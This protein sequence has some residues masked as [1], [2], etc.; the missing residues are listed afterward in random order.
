MPSPPPP[1]RSGLILGLLVSVFVVMGALVA[2]PRARAQSSYQLFESGPVRPMALSP[3]GN[4]LFVTNTPDGQLE[5][6]DVATNGSLIHRTSVGVGL[7]PVAV[8]AR[9]DDEVWVVNHLSDSVSIVALSGP[10]PRVVRTLLVGDEPNDIVFAGPGGDRAFVSAAHRGQSAPVPDGDYDVPG[11]GRADVYVFDAANLGESLEGDRLAVVT[12]FG[13]RPRALA[14]NAAGDRVYVAVFRSGNRTAVLNEGAVCDTSGANRTNEVVQGPCV[15]GFGANQTTSPGGLPTPLKNHAGA[16]GPETGLIVQQDRDGGATGAWLDELGRDWS[17]LIRFDLPDEDVFTLDAS[18]PVPVEIG[19]PFAGVGTTLFNMAVHPITGRIFVTNT[20]ARN[21]V[22]FEGPGSHVSTNGL[23]PGGEPASVRGDLARSRITIL[24]PGSG[25]VLPRHLNKHIPYGVV[26]VPAGVEERSLAT[27]LG[28]AFSADGSTVYVAGF[29]SSRIGV[30][31]VAGLESDTFAVQAND[32]IP[33]GGGGPSSVLRLGDRLVVTTRF[34]NALRVVDPITKAEFQRIP[35]TNPE[36][37]SVIAG[38][39]F[40][41]DANLTGSNGEASCASC[42]LFGDMDDLAWDLGDPDADVV[43]NGNPINPVSQFLCLISGTL[44]TQFHPHKGPMATQSLRGLENMGPQHWRGDRQGDE[45]AAFEA[46]N[47]A[48]PGLVGRDEGELTPQQMT[49]FREFAL[50]LRYPPNPIRRLDNGLRATPGGPS[51]A[52]GAV[53]YGT[54]GNPGPT[55]DNL[56]DCQGCHTLDAATGHFG[57]NGQSTFDAEPQVFKVPHLRN[58]YQ[59][60]GAFGFPDVGNSDGPFTHQGRQVRSTGFSHDGSI[61]TLDR[62]L[63]ANVFTLSA[64]EQEDLEAFMMVFP[65]DFAPMVGQQVTL[66]ASLLAG[67]QAAALNA[68]ADLLLARSGT[69]FDSAV[70]GG[71]VNECD[72]IARVVDVGSGSPRGFLRLPDGTF[73]PDDG[74]TPIGEAALRAMASVVGQELTFSCVPPGSGSRMALDRDEDQIPNGL[75]NCA[76]A[77]NG[78]GGGT[79]VAG[80]AAALAT[81]CVTDVDCGVGGVCSTAQEDADLDGVGDAC[82]PALVPEPEMVWLLAAGSLLLAAMASR[83]GP[84]PLR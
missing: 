32:P 59:K 17:P 1:A 69:P 63:G 33:V 58:A 72:A 48:F 2:V 15:V 47:V 81:D 13:D 23:K 20:E 60:V 51:E 10:A 21:Q 34:D 70:L 74:G 77:P 84:R 62:F 64:A 19:A 27:P 12:L 50:Q 71:S 43:A 82:E 30:Y 4:R 78:P 39:P 5:V 36:P 52:N 6:F 61:D 9:S 57:G 55:S 53:L 25:A 28:M 66:S 67:P 11:Q 44:C 24:D 41:Y 22:R 42:H 38:R 45:V 7:E 80:D 26:P 46:F 65:S 14:R 83:R 56:T 18:A 31:D 76:G 79:C 54:R 3:S 8:A 49:A 75:D 35:L 29:G 40:L 73:L 37:P 68:R 16:P